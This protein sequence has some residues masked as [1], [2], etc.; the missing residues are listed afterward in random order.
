MK[1]NFIPEIIED[2]YDLK[3]YMEWLQ[4]ERENVSFEK[5]VTEYGFYDDD[6]QRQFQPANG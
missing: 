5:I 2:N 3:I 1:D 4:S 6:M